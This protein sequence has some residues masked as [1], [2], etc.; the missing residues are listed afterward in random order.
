LEIETHYSGDK[1]MESN[2]KRTRTSAIMTM[3]AVWIIVAGLLETPALAGNTCL[4]GR[5]YLQQ[6]ETMYWILSVEFSSTDPECRLT[7]VVVN[8]GEGGTL[9]QYP[10]QFCYLYPHIW[11]GEGTS[12][13]TIYMNPPMAP[14]EEFR[15][16]VSYSVNCDWDCG[17][18][19]TGTFRGS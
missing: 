12:E 7:K 4:T 13:V 14:E 9:S 15:P 3:V 11:S 5:I 19:I 1:T 17:Q 18:T 16:C 8:L 10:G 6:G 2:E